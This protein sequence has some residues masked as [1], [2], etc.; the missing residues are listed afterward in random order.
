MQ[1]K[2]VI[3]DTDPN[4]IAQID[5]NLH[6]SFKELGLKGIITCNSE[7]PSLVR[8]G[9]FGRVPVLELEGKYWSGAP[10]KVF[11]VSACINLLKKVCS[12]TQD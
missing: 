10:G 9:L 4:R 11:S 1:L 6:L 3:W 12:L 7:P 2:I 8:A 5:H